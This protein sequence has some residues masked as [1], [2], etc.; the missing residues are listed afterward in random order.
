MDKNK[1][2]EIWKV[3]DGFPMYQISNQGKVYSS[4]T[5]RVLKFG[6]TTNG[7][8]QVKLY[9]QRGDK[10]KLTSVHRLVAKAFLNLIESKD[11]VHHVN[12]IKSDNRVCNLVVKS[13]E[14]V[15]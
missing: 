14:K 1:D 6:T 2:V 7:F 10:G 15:F 12:G 11:H 3:I 8:L 5:K 4:Y 13:Y 9:S